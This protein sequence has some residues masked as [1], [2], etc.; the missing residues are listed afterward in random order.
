MTS[1]ARALEGFSGLTQTTFAHQVGEWT[2]T[3]HRPMGLA[4]KL[5][6]CWRL[7]HTGGTKLEL[8]IKAHGTFVSLLSPCCAGHGRA[9]NGQPACELC[10]RVMILPMSNCVGGS[11]SQPLVADLIC[12][13]LGPLEAE[14]A[15]ALLVSLAEDLWT[16][17]S[18]EYREQWRMDAKLLAAAGRADHS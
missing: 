4:G 8:S 7:T 17:L 1:M 6:S 5:P 14:V 11:I 10:G 16:V 2:L 18:E 3:V 12:E 15:G 9:R 13:D